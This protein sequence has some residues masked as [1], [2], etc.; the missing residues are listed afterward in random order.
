MIR[1]ASRCGGSRRQAGDQRSFDSTLA[2]LVQGAQGRPGNG[3]CG[4]GQSVPLA[5]WTCR[6]ENE[7]RRNESPDRVRT[8]CGRHRW[9]ATGG[10]SRG[11]RGVRPCAPC[12]G[13]FACRSW[14]VWESGKADRFG[15]WRHECPVVKS[16]AGPVPGAPRGSGGPML[17]SCQWFT[18]TRHFPQS[19]DGASPWDRDE[20]DVSLADGGVYRIF[21]DRRV[22]RWFLE[23]MVD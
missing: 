10:R 13:G 11:P 1:R 12:C 2:R 5:A 22:G 18:P 16:C 3:G 21:H 20:W 23:G 6:S 15:L 9:T 19:R 8:V 17:Q 4:M 14:R 7:T